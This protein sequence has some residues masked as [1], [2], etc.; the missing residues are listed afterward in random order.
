MKKLYL[1]LSMLFAF[2]AAANAVPAKKLQKVITL[3]NGT[4]VSVELRGDEYL[5]WWEGTDGTAYRATADENVFEAFDLEAQKPAAAARRARAEQGRVARLAR[6]KNSLKGADDK[7][8]GL[9]GDHIT[10]K[11]VK[12]GL[13]VLV[14]FKNKKFA[15]GHD[16]EYYKNVINGKDFSDEEEGYVGSV[17]DYFLA[18]SN[19]QF[20]LDFDVVGPV[21]M[22][23][24]YGYYGNDGAYQKD[25]KVYE[26]IK[27]ACDG[28]QD[29]V[30]LKDY[31]WD[32]DGEADQVFF[33]YAGLGQ[34][35]GGSAGTVW[36]HESEL[37]YWPCGVLSY[38]T[39]KINT[40][41]CANELQPET[42]GSSRYISAGIGTICHEFSHCLGFADMYDT[43]GGGG[44]GMSVFDVM[45]QGS[46]N[47]NGF[48]PCNYTAF[49]RIYAGWVEA[50]E[51]IDPATV[52][53][54]K[55]VSDYGR[56]FIMYNYKNTNEYFL[57]ENRQNTGW[58][59]GLYGSNGLLIVHVNYVPSR[60]ANNSVNSSAE[61]IQCCTVVNADGSRENTQYS[62][63]GDLYP[64]EVKGVTM[65]DE[66]TDESEPAAKLY[67]KNSDNSYALG[68]PITQIKRSKGS[69]S[70]LVCGGDAN[71]VIDNTFNGVVDGINGVTVAKKTADNRIYS[72]DGRYLGTDASALGKGIYVVGGKKIVK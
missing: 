39:G 18:Q 53:D 26:M 31:D 67:T 29:K 27:E 50:I 70:F 62:L 12:K 19:G 15:D 60:W 23:K 24:N 52:K 5:S 49:E 9:G 43:T 3:T 35:S 46:Y 16:L 38:S 58:D 28:I 2:G 59:K 6:V 65:N 51:L 69:I 14:D 64:Y 72:I 61:K 68:I 13:V 33:L 4:Q 44:Y 30:N 25:E 17:R 10:Y 41:A 71:N 22:S 36:P 45:D 47:G 56:P 32:G 42:Q 34:A 40:Y 8:R 1:M 66:F 20:E 21:T 57:M 11:G 48:V 7:M 63:Q 54:M 37:R 55:S